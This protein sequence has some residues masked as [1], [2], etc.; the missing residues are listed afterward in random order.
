MYN[1][2][3]RYY[4]GNTN[5]IIY[6]SIILA[7]VIVGLIRFKKL[8][9]SNRILLLLLA[10]T[11]FA[12]LLGYY[13]ALTYKNNSPVS[14]SFILVEFGFFCLAF[15][16]DSRITAIKY[17]FAALLVFALVNGLFFQPF[18]NTQNFNTGLLLSLFEVV[19]YF[20]FLARYFSKVDTAPVTQF[21][22]FWTGLGF[23]LF[24][25][26]FVVAFSFLKLAPGKTQWATVAK[27]AR[28]YANYLLYLLYIPAF[29]SQQKKLRDSAPGK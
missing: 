18:L 17:F 4:Y 14:N 29:L 28:Q 13:C 16:T 9:A 24:A 10:I 3:H 7:G 20:L 6:H 11:P 25:I 5:H 26:V 12:E 27:F 19:I 1:L 8:S 2:L 15:Y 23:M 22:L 21:P